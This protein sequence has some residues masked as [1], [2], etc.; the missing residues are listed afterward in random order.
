M[1]RIKVWSVGN[2]AREISPDGQE[3]AQDYLVA[4]SKIAAIRFIKANEMRGIDFESA[5]VH[6]V[7][8]DR[9]LFVKDP[10]SIDRLAELETPT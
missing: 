6:L 10:P 1:I 4:P 9:A 3:V 5:A 2:D 8:F 7:G